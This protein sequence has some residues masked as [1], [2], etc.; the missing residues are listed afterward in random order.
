VD[1][2]LLVYVLIH[3][4]ITTI[5]ELSDIFSGVILQLVVNSLRLQ[6]IIMLDKLKMNGLMPTLA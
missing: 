1:F 6:S 5:K 2:E 4:Y 3:Q